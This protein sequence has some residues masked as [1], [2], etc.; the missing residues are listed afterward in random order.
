MAW[1]Q[2][3]SIYIQ[4]TH[5]CVMLAL[6][7]K[8]KQN[9]KCVFSIM[10]FLAKS[11]VSVPFSFCWSMEDRRRKSRIHFYWW[12]YQPKHSPSLETFET[13]QQQCFGCCVVGMSLVFSRS[14]GG[15]TCT[16]SD[17]AGTRRNT[18]SCVL[19]RGH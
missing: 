12:P 4:K 7:I 3:E 16:T 11:H 2:N 18:W 13:S 10:H 17:K 8:K 19:V 5:F 1:F 6:F 15:T 14:Q 9:F